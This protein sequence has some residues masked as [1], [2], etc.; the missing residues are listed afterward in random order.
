MPKLQ[1]PEYRD[2]FATTKYPFADSATL[3]NG[4]GDFIGEAIFLDASFYAI[5]MTHRAFLSE[6]RITNEKAT[7][8]IGDENTNLLA[9]A[10]FDLV[11][12]PNEVRFTDTL[13]RPAGIMVSESTRLATFQSWSLGTHIFDSSETEFAAR[14]II[15]TPEIGVLG[16]LLDDGSV[17]ADDIWIVG[18]DGVV[19]SNET[20]TVDKPGFTNETETHQVIRVDIVGDPLFRR[21]LC[22]NVFETPFLLKT[23]TF[24]EGCEKVVCGPDKLG[25]LKI[26]AGTQDAQDSI[27]RIRS[28]P[29]GLVIEA[30]GEKLESI[31]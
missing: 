23:I 12:P 27:L 6:I 31:V 4:E 20:I 26:T 29:E 24:L 1:S 25:D 5:G 14:V 9:S 10:E 3:A 7:L 13:G 17:F 11:T 22:G 19:V 16:I 8:V 28:V 15:P 21:R 2:Y 30:V 18:D